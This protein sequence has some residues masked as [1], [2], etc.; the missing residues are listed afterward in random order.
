MSDSI[1]RALTRSGLREHAAMNATARMRANEWRRRANIALIIVGSR[2][3]SSA[4]WASRLTPFWPP[5]RLQGMGVTMV[6]SGASPAGSEASSLQKLLEPIAAELHRVEV[7]LGEQVQ[8]FDPGVGDYI[9]YVLGGAG[10]R[11]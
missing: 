7:M 1:S 9:Q 4:I 3:T 11:L 8:G 5:R 10:K 6:S 2:T